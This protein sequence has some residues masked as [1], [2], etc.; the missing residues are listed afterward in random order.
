[1]SKFIFT[2]FLLLICLIKSSL[3]IYS[4]LDII[5]NIK[6]YMEKK[7]KKELSPLIL[8]LNN[9]MD[10]IDYDIL[11]KFQKLIL[12]KTQLNTIIVFASNI[13]Q[14]NGG[15]NTFANLVF[16]ELEKIIKLDKIKFL[17]Y[18]QL[19]IDKWY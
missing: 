8:D 19:V 13:Q 14:F 2:L 15:I 3:I 4:P 17:F 6:K 11:E 12:K 1:M 16:Y 5:E 18:F 7:K 10:S 9:L